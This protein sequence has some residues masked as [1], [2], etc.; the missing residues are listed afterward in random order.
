MVFSL[1]ALAFL[2][3]EVEKALRIIMRM[4]IDGPHTVRG[5]AVLGSRF[6]FGFA[7]RKKIDWITRS[8]CRGDSRLQ[9]LPA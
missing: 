8:E 2:G 7:L 6:V 1:E 5:A 4:N 3:D 9:H